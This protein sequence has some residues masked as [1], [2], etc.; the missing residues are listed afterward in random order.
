MRLLCALALFTLMKSIQG[1]GRDP[2][3]RIWRGRLA[4]LGAQ[5]TFGGPR[6]SMRRG[7]PCER[8]PG[9]VPWNR[10]KRDR[11]GTDCVVPS[12]WKHEQGAWWR[13]G[14]VALWSRFA[15]DHTLPQRPPTTSTLSLHTDFVHSLSHH[16]TFG[17]SSPPFSPSHAPHPP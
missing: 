14:K 11:R 4:R 1:G 2:A 17:L 13:R 5:D 16:G 9:L 7:T 6:R 15:H 3:R 8:L 10:P 12:A